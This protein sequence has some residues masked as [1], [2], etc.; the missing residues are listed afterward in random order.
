MARSLPD[1]SEPKLGIRVSATS[2]SLQPRI[3]SLADVCRNVQEWPLRVGLG[4]SAVTAEIGH[5]QPFT[6]ASLKVR[7]QI[8]KRPFGQRSSNRRYLPEAVIRELGHRKDYLTYYRPFSDLLQVI[9]RC[10]L[11]GLYQHARPTLE[12]G[13]DPLNGP[14]GRKAS[15]GVGH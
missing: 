1:G 6:G 13:A 5:K 7:L 15:D 14:E 4:H 11:A 9:P 2:H 8:R 10:N 12:K 3:I